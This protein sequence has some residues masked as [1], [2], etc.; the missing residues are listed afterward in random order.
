[1]R[2]A[3]RYEDMSP[4][5]RLTVIQQDDGDV[6]IMCT[7]GQGPDFS[8]TAVEFCMP[9]SGGGQ[10]ENTHRVLV[11]LLEAIEQDNKRMKQDR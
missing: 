5:G 8:Q 2:Q 4:K 9:M 7:S 10:S 6:I 3:S 11:A 1:M